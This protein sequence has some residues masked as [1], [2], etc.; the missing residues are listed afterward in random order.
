METETATQSAYPLEGKCLQKQYL[1][2]RQVIF[3]K[4]FEG[5]AFIR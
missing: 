4:K 2:H 5:L 3:Q 1:S